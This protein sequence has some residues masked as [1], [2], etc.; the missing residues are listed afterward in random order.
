MNAFAVGEEATIR[1]VIF[2]SLFMFIAVAERLRPQQPLKVSWPLR[3]ANNIAL[4]AIN[5]L[6][7]RVLAPFSGTV[8]AAIVYEQDLALINLAELPMVV[9]ILAFILI[10]D[11][12]I[13]WQ[14]RLFHWVPLLW[15]FHRVHHTDL[16]L[17][18]T[19]GSRF[20]PVSI[21]ISMCIKLVLVL[22]FGPFPLAILVSEVLLNATSMFNHSNL[23]LPEKV[24]NA[25]RWIM[26]T[27]NMHRIHHSQ[28][29]AEHSSNFGFNFTWWDRVLGTYRADADLAADR[30]I[31]GIA[32]FDEIKSVRVDRLLTQPL[33]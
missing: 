28:E 7:L 18:V 14:H 24:D 10:F 8:Y 23:R 31:I 27:P 19:T 20:H 17:D 4:S 32:G 29:A 22:V 25:I 1:L 9:S 16:D 12:A 33:Q 26:V 21:V 3:W 13:Y 15:R 6:F 11:F 2:L 30:I 5:T